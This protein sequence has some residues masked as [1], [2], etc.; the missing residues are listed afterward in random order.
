MDFILD[1]LAL[2][3]FSEGWGLVL[4]F[5]KYT[6]L[7]PFEFLCGREKD[8]EAVSPRQ[9]NGL[10]FTRNTFISNCLVFTNNFPRINTLLV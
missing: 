1:C 9:G 7:S 2:P 4:F 8:A 10:N 3:F 6:L 5:C